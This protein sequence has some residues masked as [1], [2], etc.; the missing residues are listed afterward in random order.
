M[1][2]E[3]D[4]LS[5]LG[6]IRRELCESY[7]SEGAAQIKLLYEQEELRVAENNCTNARI[8]AGKLG[9]ND[10]ERRAQLDTDCSH[11]RNRM[12]ESETEVI[13]A[14]IQR[15]K[16]EATFKSALAFVNHTHSDQTFGQPK[17]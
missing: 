8:T 12:I 14:R 5:R 3:S 4:L 7:E 15:Q 13:R 6:K 10:I 16:L 17:E 2:N 9:K 1:T 11:E